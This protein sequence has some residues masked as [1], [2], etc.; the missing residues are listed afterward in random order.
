[1]HYS[2]LGFKEVFVCCFPASNSVQLDKKTNPNSPTC[3]NAPCSTNE[4]RVQRL[5]TIYSH[6]QKQTKQ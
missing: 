4:I 6:F 1:M 5:K 2:K 3:Q